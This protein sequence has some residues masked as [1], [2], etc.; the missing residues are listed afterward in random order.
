MILLAYIILGHP[1]WK[2]G[3]IKVFAIVPERELEEQKQRF[4]SLVSS[5]RL[6]ISTKN[7]NFIAPQENLDRKAI[8]NQKSIDA[9]LTIVG[10]QSRA[11]RHEREKVFVGYE[12]IGNVLFVSASKEIPIVN[13]GENGRDSVSPSDRSSQNGDSESGAGEVSGGELGSS[14]DVTDGYGAPPPER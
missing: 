6:P 9:D 7:I 1:E 5:G 11:L 10:L 4:T 14:S 8:I 12:Q 2:G 3:I 13:E